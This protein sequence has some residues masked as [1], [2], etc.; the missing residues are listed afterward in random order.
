MQ[1]TL[2]PPEPFIPLPMGSAHYVAALQNKSGE[3]EALSRVDEETWDRFTPLVVLVGR[4][5][6][7]E[8]INASTVSDWMKK[9]SDA[10]GGHALFLDVM[11]LNPSHPVKAAQVVV[12]L[13]ERIY[14]AARRRHLAFVPVLPVGEGNA[15]HSRLV[16]D[17]VE[18][19]GRG[20]ALRYP[21]RTLAITAGKQG[22]YLA[23]T[24]AAAG[25]D[26]TNADLL[27][28][29]GFLDADV[30]MRAEDLGPAITAAMSVGEWRSVVLLGTS[31]PSMLSCIP[32]GTVGSL[33]RK[34][35]EIWRSLA[36]AK[37]SRMPTYGDYGIQ[38]SRPPDGGGPSMRASIRYT[39]EAVTLVARGQ[40]S[41]LQEGKEQYIGLCQDL[42]A[43]KEFCGAGYTWGD[44]VIDGCAKGT[45]EPGSQHLWRG[46][47]TS[48][49]VRFVT[50][51]LQRHLAA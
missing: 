47:G 33:A 51:Q 41:V 26:V 34:E 21:I 19:D 16:R 50:D 38:H 15:D 7:P 27:I 36:D 20:V 28:D 37:L 2:F 49:H 43:C 12:P 11:R 46:A 25:T 45:V 3:L 22:E 8:Q 6:Q 14:W 18:S 24:V 44:D 5:E 31:M 1:P 30:E 23:K 17:A 9:L 40:G 35:W 48:H 13:L 42:V 39:V 10:V 29:L 4:K 32:E